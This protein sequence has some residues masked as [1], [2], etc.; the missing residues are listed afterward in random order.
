VPRLGASVAACPGGTLARVIIDDARVGDQVALVAANLESR[1]AELIG[2][3]LGVIEHDIPALRGDRRIK[4]LLEAS[5]AENVS[6]ATHMLRHGIDTAVIEAPAAAV[7]YGRRLA[8]RDVPAAAL[9]RAYRIGQARYLQQFIEELLRLTPGDHIEGRA[10]LRIVEHV[11]D[12]VDRVVEQILTAYEQARESWVRNRG[13][14]TAMRVRSILQGDSHDEPTAHL[15][16]GYQLGQWHV[17]LIIWVGEHA[18][19]R[20]ALGQLNNVAAALANAVDCQHNPLFVPCDETT[21]WVWLPLGKRGQAKRDE[22]AKVITGYGPHVWGALGEPSAGIDGFRRTHRQ[23]ASAQDVALAG[24]PARARV[25]AFV[26]VAPI[27]MMCA[28]LDAARAWVIETLGPLATDTERHARLRESARVFLSTGGS[29]TI[30]AE[31]LFL[32]RNSAQY[33]IQKAE[34]LRGRPLREGRLDV[35]LALLACHW[36]GQ[37]VLQPAT[38]DSR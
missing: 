28:D 17:G 1:L 16:L 35:E 37:T 7:E 23:A 19:D 36:L 31:E 27:A 5:V 18:T 10:A 11:S 38:P 2:E 30:T 15:A 34:E 21:A 12:Y 29:Y 26:D 13:A 24:R 14:V 33:R 9:V 32:H 25:T 8:Q 6:T 20:D 4:S 22:L 3:I